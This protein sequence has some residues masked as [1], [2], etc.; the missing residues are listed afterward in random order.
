M[1]MAKGKVIFNIER[2]K[3]CDICI[4]ACPQDSLELSPGINK[5]GYHYAVLVQDNCTGCTNCALVCPE[6]VI[7]V[8]R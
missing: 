4:E 1:A 5:Q 2:C 8:Y 6:A 3:G 7:T